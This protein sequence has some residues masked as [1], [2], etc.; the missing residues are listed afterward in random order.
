MVWVRKDISVASKP[1]LSPPTH[2]S[3]KRA[4]PQEPTW[5]RVMPKA[6]P[7]E[8]ESQEP[9]LKGK[10]KGKVVDVT[11]IPSSSTS[12]TFTPKTSITTWVSQT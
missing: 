6:T 9:A 10:G 7:T 4:E 11:N 5:K 12:M 8:V 1:C 2:V 3:R